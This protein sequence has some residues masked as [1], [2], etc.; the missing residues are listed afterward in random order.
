MKQS[1]YRWDCVMS[2]ENDDA[3]QLIQMVGCEN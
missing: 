3:N 1:V 2:T